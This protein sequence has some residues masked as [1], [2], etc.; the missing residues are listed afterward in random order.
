MLS[1]FEIPKEVVKKLDFY[2]SRFFW[3]GDGHKKKYRLTKWNVVCRPK[4]QGGLGFIDLETQNKCLF[5]KWLFKLVNENGV[6]QQLLKNKY[7]GSKTL[8]LRLRKS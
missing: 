2:R 7:L 6:W 8:S 1:F 3:Q 5:S 4:D